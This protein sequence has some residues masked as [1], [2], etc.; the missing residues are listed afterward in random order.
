MASLNLEIYLHRNQHKGA[1]LLQ[2]YEYVYNTCILY[3]HT[4]RKRGKIRWAKLLCFSRAPQKFSREYLFILYKL[5][6]TTLFKCGKRK[7]T[8]KVFP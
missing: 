8:A 3:I 2:K 1:Q 5:C 7:G 6:I 4:Y